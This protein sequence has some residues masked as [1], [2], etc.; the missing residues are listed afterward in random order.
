MLLFKTKSGSKCIET[1]GTGILVV[2]SLDIR[3]C[4]SKPTC[5]CKNQTG[6]KLREAFAG[7]VGGWKERKQTV[8]EVWFSS[9]CVF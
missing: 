9:K 3:N 4:Y 6:P 1:A 2:G 5:T 7:R 8:I